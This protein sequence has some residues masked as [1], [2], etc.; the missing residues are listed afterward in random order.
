MQENQ[1]IFEEEKQ[2]LET[3]YLVLAEQFKTLLNEKAET[4]EASDKFELEK[5]ALETQSLL[6]AEQFENL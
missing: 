2:A 6:L 3:K 1:D 5:K 4:V